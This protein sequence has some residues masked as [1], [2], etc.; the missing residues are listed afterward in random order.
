M[1][2]GP[3]Q[4]PQAPPDGEPSRG[5]RRNRRPRE[6]GTR[7]LLDSFAIGNPDDLLTLRELLAGLGRR[8]FGMLLF[9]ATLPAFIP[10]PIGGAIAGPL[11]MLIGVQLLI[12]LRRPWL[13]RFVAER[14]PH[15]HALA[16]FDKIIAPWL[17]RLEHLIKPRLTW[18]LDHR[19]ATIFTGLLLV[20]LGVL[21]SLPIPF[22]NFVFGGLLLL[23]AL[24]LLERDGALMLVSWGMGATAIAVFGVLSG[25]LAAQATRFLDR[26]I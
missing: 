22:T 9:I 8:A 3:D 19:V 1:M 16:R 7:A 4:P 20:V 12:G 6:A 18:V 2:M 10:I 11:V 24:A 5:R 26:F 15:R 13:P 25:T 14:G 17:G 23:F 21:T